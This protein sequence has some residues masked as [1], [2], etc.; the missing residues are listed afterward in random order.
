MAAGG[1]FQD[2]A[3]YNRLIINMAGLRLKRD[4]GVKNGEPISAILDR[5]DETM[6]H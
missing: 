5:V 6:R 2:F 4:E 1:V 3:A